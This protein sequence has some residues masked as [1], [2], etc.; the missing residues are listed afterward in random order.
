LDATHIA[1]W[2][3]VVS[4]GSLCVAFCAFALL[5]LRYF[6]EGVRLSLS[7]LVGARISGGDPN[8]YLAV[9]VM[10]R[11]GAP[12][13]ITHMVLYNYPTDLARRVP[14]WLSWR[15][16]WFRP[17]TFIINSIGSPGPI[18]YLLEPGRMW[19]GRAI[20]KPDLDKMIEDGRL[21]VAE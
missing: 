14:V 17:V 7:V 8:K 10:N 19:I 20:Q 13:T 15:V 12:T 16:K 1:L 5:L 3:L 11:G 4:V 2:A 18:P 6:D 9:T 21:Y